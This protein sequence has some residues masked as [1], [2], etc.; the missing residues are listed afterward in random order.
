MLKSVLA[1]HVKQINRRL[2]MNANARRLNFTTVR[3]IIMGDGLF[4]NSMGRYWSCINWG[5]LAERSKNWKIY[6]VKVKRPDNKCW[7]DI[8]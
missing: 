8:F 5:C 7:K 1:S 4:V 3:F 6:S 2:K